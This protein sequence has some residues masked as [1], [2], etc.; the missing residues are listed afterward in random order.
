MFI[1]FDRFCSIPSTAL[2]SISNGVGGCLCP[3]D[4]SAY[5]ILYGISFLCAF[6]Y[7]PP[8]SASAADAIIFLLFL[9]YYKYWSI[10]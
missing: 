4:S 10:E 9:R 1:A 2:L 5:V 8:V 3:N 6:I 7:N